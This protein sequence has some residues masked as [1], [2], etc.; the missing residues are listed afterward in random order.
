[1][2]VDFTSQDGQRGSF[3][4][5]WMTSVIDLEEE[6]IFINRTT[7]GSASRVFNTTPLIYQPQRRSS[8]LRKTQLMLPNCTNGKLMGKGTH[9]SVCARSSQIR[10]KV[11]SNR[12]D[13]LFGQGYC[14]AERRPGFTR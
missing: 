5:L 1:M 11:S 4:A 2:R 7:A 13:L 12:S 6:T 3:W 14:R 8:K 10:R 9:L